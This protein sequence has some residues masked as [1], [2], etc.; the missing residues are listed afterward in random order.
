MSRI[1]RKMTRKMKT[2]TKF[3]TETGNEDILSTDELI[4]LVE[5]AKERHA[6]LPESILGDLPKPSEIPF[7][8]D[9][10][11]MKLIM[12]TSTPDLKM[13]RAMHEAFLNLLRRRYWVMIEAGDMVPGTNEAEVLLASTRLA[14]ISSACRL[15]DF[16]FVRPY[17]ERSSLPLH[18]QRTSLGGDE[19][20][21]P[22]I[23]EGSTQSSRATLGL[24][25]DGTAGSIRSLGL[26]F[27]LPRESGCTKDIVE[28]SRFDLVMMFVIF[29]NASL[30]AIE[31][32]QD[33]SGNESQSGSSLGW[34]IVDL[35]FTCAFTVE[36]GL[37]LFVL[38]RAYFYTA[39]N[40][41]DCILVF[42]GW[43][44]TC[45]QFL[46]LESSSVNVTRE[47]RLFSVARSFRVLRVLRII[48]LMYFF[49]V[50]KA[51]L[52]GKN[53][54][55]AIAEHMQKVTILKC[56]VKAHI[57]V[58]QEITKFF[59][60][61]GTPDSFELIYTIMQSQCTV[62]EAIMMAL[63][64]EQQLGGPLALEVKSVQVSKA[65]A[66]RHQ[67]FV[68]HAHQQGML[69]T[70]EA[71]SILTPLRE[72]MQ[73]W[74]ARQ[75]ANHFGLRT[76]RRTSRNSTSSQSSVGRPGLR[77]STGSL[78]LADSSSITGTVASLDRPHNQLQKSPVV[79]PSSSES[80]AKQDNDVML[81]SCSSDDVEVLDLPA[82]K[83]T[84][85]LS[86]KK[87]AWDSNEADEHTDSEGRLAAVPAQAA[88]NCMVTEIQRLSSSSSWQYEEGSS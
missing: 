59:G 44:G 45:L 50:L 51:K 1:S 69:N 17:C 81:T 38:R 71:E 26:H 20:D 46:A 82:Q 70:S 66:E 76:S 43:A 21:L 55:L 30:M 36:F 10:M 18:F 73:A 58:Q 68:H 72:H 53:I 4:K 41:F 34:L 83:G 75:R 88:D 49:S 65:I 74:E 61:Q 31:E 42:M 79:S 12:T 52:A 60:A 63:A 67:A 62:Y 24:S 40:I 13:M 85:S 80:L 3:F 27:L 86:R 84:K 5:K 16:L 56:V 37:K 2:I 19:T 6:K 47:G 78:H 33:S 9:H 64:E 22:R 57:V 15:A 25:K 48:R 8:K 54:S 39:W 11:K 87:A 77:I 23:G 28:S 35:V 14:T 32:A 7:A 29:V